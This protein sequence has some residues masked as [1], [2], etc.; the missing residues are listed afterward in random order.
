MILG[1]LVSLII[2]GIFFLFSFSVFYV[3]I[4]DFLGPIPAFILTSI[5]FII[6]FRAVWIQQHYQ[7][8]RAKK[9][10]KRQAKIRQRKLQEQQ[11]AERHKAAVEQEKKREKLRNGMRDY[12]N[13]NNKDNK[14]P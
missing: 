8:Y 1:F 14:K 9:R 12:F 6:M 13:V 7:E 5:Y 10:K 2:G 11:E 4:E 3:A